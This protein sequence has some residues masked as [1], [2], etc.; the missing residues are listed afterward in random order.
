MPAD[1]LMAACPR[2]KARG[3]RKEK[4]LARG[5][6]LLMTKVKAKV[7]KVKAKEAEKAATPGAV[8]V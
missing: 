6:H 3:P 1:S 5:P 2:A 4:A 8:F 7:T